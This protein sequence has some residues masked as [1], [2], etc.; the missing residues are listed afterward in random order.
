M[1]IQRTT[2]APVEP[3]RDPWLAMRRGAL[4]R[5]P[6]CGEGHLFKGFL[7]VAP[8]CDSCG[9]AFHHHRADD[10]P[11][12]IVIA[13]VGHIVVGGML[14]AE[15]HGEWPLWLHIGLWPTLTIVLSLAMIRPIKGGI[16]ALQWALRMHGFGSHPDGDDMPALRP[17]PET[18]KTGTPAQ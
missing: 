18:L 12:Y 5:C 10:L 8:A 6:H 9:E 7:S 15:T 4:G 11:A 13:I 1:P 16:V 17:H 2:S 3:A 14:A